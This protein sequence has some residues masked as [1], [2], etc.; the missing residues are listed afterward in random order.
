LKVVY[1]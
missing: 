1:E